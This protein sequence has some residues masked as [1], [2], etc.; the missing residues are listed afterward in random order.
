MIKA[1]WDKVKKRTK[2]T[3][4]GNKESLLNEFGTILDGLMSTN[5]LNVDMVINILSIVVFD[6]G[7]DEQIKESTEKAIDNLLRN[8]NFDK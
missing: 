3:M 5:V 8:M 7:L 1:E 6:N 4:N 2:C